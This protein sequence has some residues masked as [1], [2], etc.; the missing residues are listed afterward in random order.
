MNGAREAPGVTVDVIATLFNGAAY[1]GEFL[2]SLEA[3]TH[4]SW[5]LWVRDDGSTDETL[6]I[7]RGAAAA[8]PRITLLQSGGPRLGPAAGFGWLLERVPP[9][10]GYVMCADQDDVW[11]PEKIGRTLSVMREA[12]AAG[13]GPVLVHTDLV[14]VDERLRVVDASFWRFSSVDPEPV[15]LRRLVVQNV[16]TGATI[17]LNRPLRELIGVMPSEA[18]YQDW[19]YACV[20]AAFGRI[21]ALR[22]ATILYRQ[23]GANAVG[24]KRVAPP[25]LAEL[26]GLAREAL[27]RTAQLR[28]DIARSARQAGAFLDRYGDRLADSDRRFLAAYAQLPGLGMFRRKLEVARLRVLP[29]HGLWRNL[30]VLLRA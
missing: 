25:R 14:V 28:A 5:R 11:L 21:V 20:A 24:A 15:S 26:P 10:A 29:S 2:A 30:G 4:R 18:V 7:V 27:A 3:Q 17:M 23:H 22:E 13:H 6:A 8:D 12:E 9:A 16:A 19:W 1:L